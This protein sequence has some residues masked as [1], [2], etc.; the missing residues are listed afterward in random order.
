MHRV[1][2]DSGQLDLFLVREQGFGPH[3]PRCHDMP[4]GQDQSALGVDHEPGCLAALVPLRIECTCTVD[5]DRY[6]AGGYSFQ[7]P[8]PGLRIGFDGRRGNH[9]D[10]ARNDEPGRKPGQKLIEKSHARRPPRSAEPGFFW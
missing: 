1:A 9:A 6:D 2:I 8:A 5:L 3:R 4:V 7:C 10:R